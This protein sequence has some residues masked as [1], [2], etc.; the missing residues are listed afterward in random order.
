MNKPQKKKL[1]ENIDFLA[2]NISSIVDTNQ[3][4]SITKTEKNQEQPINDLHPQ[5]NRSNKHSQDVSDRGNQ[6]QDPKITNG[7]E[8]GEEEPGEVSTH[9]NNEE[10]EREFPKEH[11]N[12]KEDENSTQSDD[13]LEESSQPTQVSKMQKDE[14]E[15]GNQ[16]QEEDSSNAEMEEESASKINKHNQ[17]G[18][19]QSQEEKSEVI[20]NHEEM[21]KKT[22]S[23]ALLVKPTD[24]GNTMPRNHGAN[25]DGDDPRRDAT[26]DYEFI[27]SE[28]FL[29][30]ERSQSIFYHPKYEEER[31]RERAHENGNVDASEPGE[32]QGVRFFTMM[33]D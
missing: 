4:E 30:A 24:E 1:P 28:A 5:F 20:S 27:P 26:D 11:S 33:L 12:S 7:E 21:D 32:Y 16:E 2:P 10:R 6:E 3:Q 15:Q 18:E 8:E 14:F 17:D 22:V 31:E 29:E 9:N 25:D 19:W 13:I 23:E